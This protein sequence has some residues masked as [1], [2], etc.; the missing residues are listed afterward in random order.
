MGGRKALIGAAM[1]A[2]TLAASGA[3]A[4]APEAAPAPHLETTAGRTRLIVDG[5]PFLILGGQIHNSSN[6]NAEDL[7]KALDVVAGLKANVAE[8][9]LY[10]EAI[11][12]SPGTYDF[13][14]LDR[15]V[16]GARKRGLKLVFL[17][18]GTWKNG[19][20]HYTPEWVKL[21]KA[22]FPRVIGP[23][24]EETAIVSA[25]SDTALAADAR[26]FAAVMRHIKAVDQGKSTVIMMQV[27]NEPGYFGVDR[28]YAPAATAAYDGKVP[29]E[30]AGWLAGHRATL[31]DSLKAALAKTGDRVEGT[32]REV[33][34]DLAPEAFTAWTV[35]RYIDRV[36]AAG[37]AEYALPMYSNVWLPEGGERSG[38]W[39]SGC[40]TE[41]VI[42][43]WKAGAPAIDLVAPDIYYPKFNDQAAAYAR[44]DN[45]LFVPEVNFIPYFIGFAYSTFGDYDGFGFSPFGIDDVA[46]GGQAEAIGGMLQ[47]VYANLRPLLP[48]IAAH[49]F[50][51][52]IHPVLQGIGRGEEWNWN[53]PLRDRL[54]AHVEFTAKFDPERGRGQGM[55]VEL[56]KGDFLVVGSGF[57][58]DFRE[59]DGP[60]RDAEIT[61]IEE[62]SFDGLQ[63]V[64]TRRLNGD[65]RHVELGER[66]RVLR[67]RIA[68]P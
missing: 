7:G 18:F 55:I 22:R 33:F 12:P 26:A 47:D 36:A 10:W 40:A 44:R 64:P 41:H 45:P 9:P 52:D 51:G 13:S 54:A 53:V 20:S 46:K 61:S 38:R 3:Q 24:G 23:R 28:D 30:L 25:L 27:E 59:L 66:T 63:W 68:R 49:Q 50:K 16:E 14:S 21:D 35:S 48:V 31:S 29:A 11:E 8:V 6:A 43:V 56:G 65:E 67:V 4:K 5:A 17:W 1:A 62:G 39:P 19:E 58:V 2:L 15:A 42:D 37:K 32:W 57:K 34:G 60:L